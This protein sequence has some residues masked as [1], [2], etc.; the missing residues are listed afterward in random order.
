MS[1]R[2]LERH[3]DPRWLATWLRAQGEQCAE[4]S[5]GE[6]AAQDG[7]R[8]RTEITVNMDTSEDSNRY[9]QEKRLRRGERLTAL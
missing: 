6:G 5:C 4:A 9:T 2:W 1:V 8:T 7:C 3:W